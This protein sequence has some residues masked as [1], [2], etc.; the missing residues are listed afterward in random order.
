MRTNTIAPAS[1]AYTALFRDASAR[2]W[3]AY[4]NPSEVLVAGRID[5]VAPLLRRVE[6][7]AMQGVHA[8]GCV[9]YEAASAFDDALVTCPDD[10]SFPLA[11]FA[12]F[13][14]VELLPQLPQ[15]GDLC[16]PA[17]ESGAPLDW[18]ANMDVESYLRG[19]RTVKES[20][21]AGET[22]QVNLTFRLRAGFDGSPRE[23]LRSMYEAQPT[24]QCSFLDMGSHVV[25]SAS[26]E[27]FFALDGGRLVTRPMKGTAPRGLRTEDDQRMASELQRSTKDRA[28]N[29]MIVDMI[30]NDMGRIAR[31]GSVRVSR[32]FGVERHP[33]LWQMTST[34]ECETDAGV[35]RVF[36]AL[37]PCASVTGAP[38]VQTMKIIAQLEKSPRRVYTGAL[39]FVAPGGRA[40]FNVPIRTAIVDVS[41]QDV[42]YSVGSGIVWDSTDR[43]EYEECLTKARVVTAKRPEFSLL[44]T[45]LWTPD[46]GFFLGDRHLG[47]MRDSAAFFGFPLDE[48]DF[49]GSLDKAR[50]GF[51]VSAM[52]VRVLL[53]SRGDI[54]VESVPLPQSHGP[55]P[56]RLRLAQGEVD[57][58][59]PFLYHKTTHRRIYE[60]ARASV[61]DCDDVILHND[62]GEVTET[63]IDNLVVKL[64]GALYTPPVECGLLAGMYRSR[65]LE[66]GEVAQRAIRLEDLARAESVYVVNSVRMMREAVV[67]R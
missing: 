13:D 16:T 29:I 41:A 35:A 18:S 54:H 7:A 12:L 39:G 66:R 23:L 11:W 26:P 10:G 31:T 9:S 17:S 43:G 52:R 2:V 8:V 1:T 56:V 24:D 67:L 51:A 57:P 48:Q 21:A 62:R 40:Q 6:S 14:G 53:N 32:R 20:I 47:R 63:T 45:L 59:D 15:S 64:D 19:V 25:C 60:D 42:E 28:E 49:R 44:E 55:G 5:E 4:R 34:V 30:R 61:G 50:A 22:Y 38:K 36:S 33:T 37:F 46:K 58:R 65:M 27:I 3:R